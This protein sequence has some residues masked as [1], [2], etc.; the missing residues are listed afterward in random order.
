[1][2]HWEL[3]SK[4]REIIEAGEV[5]VIGLNAPGIPAGWFSMAGGPIGWIQDDGT[6]LFLVKEVQEFMERIKGNE[7][8]VKI[9]EAEER[10]FV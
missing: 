4:C 5:E 6:S 7:P 8:I 9:F 2:K 3:E 1:M 10:E